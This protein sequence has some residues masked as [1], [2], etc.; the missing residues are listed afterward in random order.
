MSPRSPDVHFPPS[1][2]S[3]GT[4]SKLDLTIALQGSLGPGSSVA[5]MYEAGRDPGVEQVPQ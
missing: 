4:A 3:P 1:G 2:G 5:A